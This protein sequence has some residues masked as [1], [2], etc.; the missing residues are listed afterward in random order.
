[1][2]DSLEQLREHPQSLRAVELT[3]RTS[4]R[5]SRKKGNGSKIIRVKDLKRKQAEAL[6][7]EDQQPLKRQFRFAV[8]ACIEFLES[9]EPGAA[10]SSNQQPQ[11]GVPEEQVMQSELCRDMQRC[12]FF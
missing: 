6:E 11:L 1:M 4:F 10:T 12:L 8:Q 2:K 5:V 7:Q 9:P 3:S